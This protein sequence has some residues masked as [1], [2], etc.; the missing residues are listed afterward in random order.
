M[1]ASLS[2]ANAADP[3]PTDDRRVIIEPRPSHEMVHETQHA[4]RPRQ[5]SV[6][7]TMGDKRIVQLTNE[8]PVEHERAVT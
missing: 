2:P 4:V 6:R 3:S 7:R 5:R 1:V 8:D